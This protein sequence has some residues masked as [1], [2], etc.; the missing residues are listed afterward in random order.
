MGRFL[1]APSLLGA[2]PLDI[3]GGVEAL[4]GGYDWLHLD[5][6]DGHFVRNLSFGPSLAKAARRRWPDAFLDVHLMVDHPAETLPLFLSAGAS[7]ITV[8]AEAEPQ[9]LHAVLSSI[10]G[11]GIRA[12]AAIGPATPVE[13]LVP[14]LDCLD[15]ALVMSVT[16]GF[17]GQSFIEATLE[18]TR[19]LARLRAARGLD[20]YIE[21]DGGLREDN[22]ARAALAGC[23]VVVAGS[24]VFSSPDPAACLDRMRMR[25]K[26]ALADAG[27]GT[28]Q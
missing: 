2:D 8:H 6:M 14:V 13:A 3:A 21:M 18:K 17:G 27:I 9:L 16:P 5:I 26:E 23:D 25:V 11:A 12:G 20:Y 24:A 28:E 22:V 4:K 1:L 19:D 10:R 15:L 7:L